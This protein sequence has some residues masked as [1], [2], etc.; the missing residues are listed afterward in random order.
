MPSVMFVGGPWDS[1]MM[2]IADPQQIYYAVKEP[3]PFEAFRQDAQPGKPSAVQR[4]TYEKADG[5]VDP[6]I[7][8]C[9]DI[10]RVQE[11]VNFIKR[12]GIDLEPWQEQL[13]R[14]LLGGKPRETNVP[15]STDPQP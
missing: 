9:K 12:L 1:K 8:R 10:D 2:N 13:L 5:T 6:V 7:Y 11:A 14:D 15:G 4:V 3:N